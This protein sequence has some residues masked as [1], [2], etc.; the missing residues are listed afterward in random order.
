MNLF[1]PLRA[2]VFLP[3]L[4][5]CSAPAAPVGGGVKFYT[6]GNVGPDTNS[7]FTRSP[8]GVSV[9]RSYSV[10]ASSGEASLGRLRT[11]SRFA[12]PGEIGKSDFY[13]VYSYFG[14]KVTISAPGLEGTS[15]W[16]DVSFRLIGDLNTPQGT[17]NSTSVRWGWGVEDPGDGDIPE[18]FPSFY[19]GDFNSYGGDG[20]F[21][22]GDYGPF[23]GTYKQLTIRFTYGVPFDYY[24]GVTNQVYGWYSPAVVTSSRISLVDWSGFRNVRT[25]EAPASG[26]PDSGVGKA[27]LP[28]EIDGLSIIS[29]TGHDWSKPS[30][31]RLS[32]RQQNFGTMVGE[33][34][35]GD[36][37]DP[38]K[39]GLVNLLEWAFGSDPLKSDPAPTSAVR[40]TSPSGVSYGLRYLR[41]ADPAIR[42]AATYTLQSSSTLS[43]GWSPV[44]GAV[45]SAT[46]VAGTGLEEVTIVSPASETPPA[47]GFFRLAVVDGA[48]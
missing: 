48:P 17:T 29:D 20:S 1:R 13:R 35:A 2:V 14:D 45:E 28:S 44:E 15:G 7:P 23:L 27:P 25:T 34:D 16:F 37:A 11:E 4:L 12:P 6:F 24:F 38:E 9:S 30:S 39:D 22:G 26:A 8:S 3:V 41:P 10:A 19:G 47:A 32:W 46:P 21:N 33:G 5:I 36:G 43:S 40:K 31:P 42:G 18:P